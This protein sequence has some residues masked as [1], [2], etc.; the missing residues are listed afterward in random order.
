M[1]ITFIVASFSSKHC[2]ILPSVDFWPMD[3]ENISDDVSTC[4][5]TL[6]GVDK[7]PEKLCDVENICKFYVC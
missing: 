5:L 6:L 7:V 4:K 1:H 2:F 3:V